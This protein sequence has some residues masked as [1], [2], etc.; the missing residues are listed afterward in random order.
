MNPQRVEWLQH[1]P[2]FGALREDTLECLLEG[3]A[4]VQRPAGS[5][6]FREGDREQSVYVVEQG[7]VQVQKAWNGRPWALHQLG[8]GDCFGEMAL[9]DLAPR[10][11]SVCA[12]DDPTRAI[13]FGAAAL[14]RLFEHD[15][16]QFALLQMNIAREVCRRL[17]VTDELLFQVRM[18]QPLPGLAPLHSE[19]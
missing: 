5:C 9:L 3:A 1:M 2:I 18:G 14:Q 12:L 11:A 6:F 19:A 16:E 4:S 10:S 8:V 15:A 17:R 7:R 13:E